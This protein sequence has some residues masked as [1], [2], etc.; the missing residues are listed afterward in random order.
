[1]NS[2]EGKRILVTG[3]SGFIGTEM[4]RR[5]S[6]ERGTD[7]VIFCRNTPSE[8]FGQNVDYLS[9]DL[10]NDVGIRRALSHVRPNLVVHLA[11]NTGPRGYQELNR[12]Q[13]YNDNV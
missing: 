4:V 11:A 3:G 12:E 1:M 6:E 9:G 7:V 13:I 2:I 10:R 8:A 5:L